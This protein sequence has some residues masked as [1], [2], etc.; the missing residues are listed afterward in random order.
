[1]KLKFCFRILILGACKTRFHLKIAE[2]LAVPRRYCVALF[3]FLR[4]VF[5]KVPLLWPFYTSTLTRYLE[6]LAFPGNPHI[7]F[8]QQAA[9]SG[10]TLTLRTC[11]FVF[12]FHQTTF[13]FIGTYSIYGM[14][15]PKRAF[16]TGSLNIGR[17][18]KTKQ[19]N[20]QKKK[21]KINKINKEARLD[22]I[23][24]SI[25]PLWLEHPWNHENLFEIWL[26]RATEG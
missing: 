23:K 12:F 16:G 22:I 1:M 3:S 6:G 15:C 2:L 7:Y 17:Q 25:E 9:A 24:C 14:D 20:K 21:K 11:I 10:L 19:T 4:S 13:Y 18:N 8:S 26:V 5:N